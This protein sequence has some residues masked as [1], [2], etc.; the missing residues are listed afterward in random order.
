MAVHGFNAPAACERGRAGWESP[1]CCSRRGCV[2]HVA[3]EPGWSSTGLVTRIKSVAIGSSLTRGW[4]DRNPR[5]SVL[6]YSPLREPR[7][8]CE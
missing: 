8:A 3:T 2:L 7:L 4:H 5:L 1:A 6:R